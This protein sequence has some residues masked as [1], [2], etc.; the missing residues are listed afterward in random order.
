MS[1]LTLTVHAAGSCEDTTR[2]AALALVRDT[3]DD[4]FAAV[5]AN[6]GVLSEDPALARQLVEEFIT[7]HVDL[8]G[9]SKLVLGKHWR[10]ATAEQKD[11]FLTQFH[12]LVLRTYATAVTSYTGIQ[13]EYL[14]MRAESRENFA[15][16]R[17]LIPRPG[18]E[19]VKVNYRLHCRNNVWKLCDVNIA[20]V[21]MVT[22]YRSAFS[23]EV[24]KSGLDGLIKVLKQKNREV[25]A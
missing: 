14:P 18:G 22:T 9:F 21:S 15:T 24:K 8:K 11:Q 17:T 10:R 5:K 20:G 1:A 3:T 12:A 4:L 23:A 16:V 2:D 6:N 25:G 7:P 19:G 13:V